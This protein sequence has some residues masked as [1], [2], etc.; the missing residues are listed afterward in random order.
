[1]GGGASS[2]RATHIFHRESVAVIAE[3]RSLPIARAR[4]R[5]MRPLAHPI[6][7]ERRSTATLGMG[8]PLRRKPPVLRRSAD[9]LVP[10]YSERHANPSSSV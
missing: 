3:G 10:V 6:A 9:A 4:E 1:M 7:A 5:D 8:A 2:E